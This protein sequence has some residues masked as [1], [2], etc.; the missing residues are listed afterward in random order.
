[1]FVIEA[2]VEAIVEGVMWLRKQ[3]L[4]ILIVLAVLAAI[5]G[6]VRWNDAYY[7]RTGHYDGVV[8]GRVMTQPTFF[9]ADHYFVALRDSKTGQTYTQRVDFA[10]YAIMKEG[11]KCTIYWSGD[12]G[13]IIRWDYEAQ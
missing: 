2:I 7:S 6:C 1:M 13:N 12:S 10:T 11:T 4:L 8:V 5:V 9:D 3:V